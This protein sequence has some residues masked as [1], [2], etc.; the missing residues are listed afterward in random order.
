VEDEFAMAQE[1]LPALLGLETNVTPTSLTEENVEAVI[2]ITSLGMECHSNPAACVTANHDFTDVYGSGPLLVAAREGYLETLKV[3]LR[4]GA[5][6]EA[7]DMYGTN[8]LLAASEAGHVDVVLELLKYGADISASDNTGLTPLHH[9]AHEGQIEIVKVLLEYGACVSTA[10]NAGLT[11]LHHGDS[12]EVVKMLLQMIGVE[13]FLETHLV[14]FAFSNK[15]LRKSE[16]GMT[17]ELLGAGAVDI[18]YFEPRFTLIAGHFFSSAL[19]SACSAFQTEV[20]RLLLENFNPHYRCQHWDESLLDFDCDAFSLTLDLALKHALEPPLKMQSCCIVELLLRS[21]SR[22]CYT[23]EDACSS[24][25]P[26]LLS[27]CRELELISSRSPLSEHD[28]KMASILLEHGA[29]TE[30]LPWLNLVQPNIDPLQSNLTESNLLTVV[31]QLNFRNRGSNLQLLVRLMGHLLSA[32]AGTT[33]NK[34]FD[35]LWHEVSGLEDACGSVDPW[36]YEG[37]CVCGGCVFDEGSCVCDR[38]KIGGLEPLAILTATQNFTES[39]AEAAEILLAAG[40]DANTNKCSLFAVIS[41]GNTCPSTIRIL[42]AL[43]RHGARV[44]HSHLIT[45]ALAGHIETMEA[46]LE[47]NG[48]KDASD[49]DGTTPLI[50]AARMG[51]IDIMRLLLQKGHMGRNFKSFATV[52]GLRA[53]TALG[54]PRL[55]LSTSSNNKNRFLQLSFPLKGI[56]GFLKLS[57]LGASVDRPDHQGNTPLLVACLHGN[58]SAV[59]LLMKAGANPNAANAA[60]CTPLMETVRGAIAMNTAPGA[61]STVKALVGCGADKTLVANDGST[62]LSIAQ[63]NA[64]AQSIVAWV[65][66]FAPH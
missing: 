38:W 37:N 62:A 59:R 56:F 21:H 16:I 15:N 9:G 39:H 49:G 51:N 52:L 32:G 19:M 36:I 14:A 66:P 47:A 5:D 13:L 58:P 65:R 54:T 10:D 30:V 7:G 1:W 2:I 23:C 44:T 18:S 28:V 41:S 31:R 20:V 27:S 55:Q 17:L 61:I 8:P 4:A 24:A 35:K 53:S 40:A 60:G 29:P 34:H 46:L 26:V 42:V 12:A 48:E 3:L 64:N 50:A 45:A 57:G 22:G 43:L 33:Y 6:M 25:C 63:S 11:P